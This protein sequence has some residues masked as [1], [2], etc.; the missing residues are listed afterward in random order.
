M[1]RDRTELFLS[2]SGP[3]ARNNNIHHVHLY[4]EALIFSRRRVRFSLFFSFLRRLL[5][6]KLRRCEEDVKD[7]RKP[8]EHNGATFDSY[9]PFEKRRVAFDNHIFLE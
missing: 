7:T 4:L 1:A 5:S 9:C 3:R 6:S 2:I 8:G